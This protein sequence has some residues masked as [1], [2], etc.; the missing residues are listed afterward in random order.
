M[1]AVQK[2][3]VHLPWFIA[4][5][6]VESVLHGG[7]AKICMSDLHAVL[8]ICII[9]QRAQVEKLEHY[10]EADVQHSRTAGISQ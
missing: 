7:G 9:D 2:D 1:S 3:A 5:N 4:D 8:P 6:V 10:Y